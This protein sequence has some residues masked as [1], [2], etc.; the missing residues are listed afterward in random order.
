MAQK[1]WLIAGILILVAALGGYWYGKSAGYAK[2]DG[3]GYKR[4]ETDFKKL[5]EGVAK[6]AAAEAAKAANPFQ[7][8]NPLANVETNAFE[9]VKKVLNPF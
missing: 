7:V 8:V 3:A 1:N 4:A 6:K 9:K 5:E 2:G